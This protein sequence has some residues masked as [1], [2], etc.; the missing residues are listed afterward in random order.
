MTFIT[1]DRPD[2]IPLSEIE[3][4]L[5][6]V[7]TRTS[8]AGLAGVLG[9]ADCWRTS[10]V[11]YFTDFRPLD[12]VHDIALGLIYLPVD[13]AP[14][15]FVGEGCLEYAES[16]THF[17][18]ET[19]AALERR[20]GGANA[21]AGPIGLAGHSLIPA[22]LRDA[23][24][25]SLGTVPLVPTD[26][27]AK[28]KARKS[29][30]ELTQM[31]RAARI[32][33]LAMHAVH[34]ALEAGIR[35]ERDLGRA[36]DIAMINAGADT[37]AYLSMVQAGPRSAYSLAM[38]TDRE[39]QSGD[40]VMTDIGARFGVYSADGGRGFAFGDITE[41]QRQIIETAAEAVERGMET[42]RPG[43]TASTLNHA[44]Q[45][46]LLDRG[47]A[48]YSK[49]A[50][51]RGTGHGTGIDPEEELPWIGPNDTTVLEQGMV[52]TLKAAINVPEVG[53]LRTERIVHVT[54]DGVEALDDFPL[55]NYW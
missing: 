3:G 50:M 7:K 13:G 8:A 21:P 20:L 44:I 46:V 24:Q 31:R 14:I 22:W 2:T 23:A 28:E 39:V 26:V 32:T 9:Y 17:E 49:E 37:P 25:A 11:R 45:Q 35:S 55:R 5:A 40:L 48:Q 18:V 16:V 51:G 10:N 54:A 36:A 33:D 12:G 1:D 34:D 30:W 41:Y 47:F 6:A 29:P 38:P 15:L 4:R 43:I 19:F 27:L 52:F 53:G 42:V